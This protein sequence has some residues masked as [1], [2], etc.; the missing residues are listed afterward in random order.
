MPTVRKNISKNME[1]HSFLGLLPLFPVDVLE[2][3]TKTEFKICFV[4]RDLNEELRLRSHDAG[5]F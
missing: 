5:T 4:A 2:E 1:I 3:V